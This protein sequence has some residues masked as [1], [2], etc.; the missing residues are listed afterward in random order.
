MIILAVLESYVPDREDQ[1]NLLHLLY[2][3]RSLEGLSRDPVETREFLNK[4]YYYNK[5]YFLHFHIQFCKHYIKN[6]LI[7]E[8]QHVFQN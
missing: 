8:F 5:H 7:I 3:S 4:N 1:K 2:Y 6:N